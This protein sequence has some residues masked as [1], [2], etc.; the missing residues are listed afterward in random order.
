MKFDPAQGGFEAM[1]AEELAP[2]KHHVDAE[3]RQA[4]KQNTSR[5]KLPRPREATTKY[6]F[7]DLTLLCSEGLDSIT[8]VSSK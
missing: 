4:H 8:N 2:L 1:F 6:R 7:G 5:K 3:K